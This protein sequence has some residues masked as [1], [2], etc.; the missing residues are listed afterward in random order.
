MATTYKLTY[1]NVTGRGETIRLIFA[2]A[3]IKFEDNRIQGSEWATLKTS[4]PWGN[5]PILQVNGK[6]T[7]GQSM[8]IARYVAREA[9]L[10]G[11]TSLEQALVDSVAETINEIRE[12]VLG[13]CMAA[14]ADKKTAAVNDFT[15][16]FLPQTL[17]KIDKFHSS[18]NDGKGFLVGDKM[19]W[20]D[21]HFYVTIEVA[22]HFVPQ[23]AQIVKDQFP[24][25][26]QL[27]ERVAAIPKVAEYLKKRPH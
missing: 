17:T 4:T 1:F 14:E 20:A 21:L 6:T 16:Q 9:G 7:I 2:A 19:T 11:K 27:Y 15:T 10:I 3:G 25:L 26:Q 5:L 12:K 24:R 22:T 18:N 23:T 13:S 8:A